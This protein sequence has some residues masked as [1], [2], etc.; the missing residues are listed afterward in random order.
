MSYENGFFKENDDLDQQEKKTKQF[1]KQKFDAELKQQWSEKLEKDFNLSRNIKPKLV[2]IRYLVWAGSIAASLLIGFSLFSI[3]SPQQERFSAVALANNYLKESIYDHPGSRKSVSDEVAELR[4]NAINDYL[5]K[6]Y[7]KAIQNWERLSNSQQLTVEDHFYL[8]LS[9]LYDEQLS[10]AIDL[11][12]DDRVFANRFEQ[13]QKWFL[14]LAYLLNGQNA[15][16]QMTLKKI[17]EEEWNFAKAQEI[18]AQIK[19]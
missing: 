6:N 14:G 18:L 8:A 2:R 3:F 19:K 17:K 10:D 16:A 9:Y 5:E 4:Q 11:L 15:E 1:L 7:S 12:K 13:E